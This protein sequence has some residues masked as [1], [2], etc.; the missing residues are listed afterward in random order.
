VAGSEVIETRPINQDSWAKRRHWCVNDACGLRW[1]TYEKNAPDPQF[2]I[3]KRETH[4][5]NSAQPT[6]VIAPSPPQELR[7]TGESRS[8]SGSDPISSPVF[9]DPPDLS[10]DHLQ[11]A[12]R[13]RAREAR[14]AAD[15]M[16]RTQAM[17]AAFC[18]EWKRAYSGEAY[19][20]LPKDAGQLKTFAASNADVT[21][22]LWRAACGRYLLCSTP[23]FAEARHPLSLLVGSFNQFSGE[24]K[25]PARRHGSDKTANNVA[26]LTDWLARE[27]AK[28]RGENR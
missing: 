27:E 2:A 28:E 14:S 10:K 5:G 6:T 16:Q 21:E 15:R 19:R 9:L 18:E 7:E 22:P 20:V 13:G 3:H 24:A 25:R 8:V 4:H 26:V 17:I 12:D 23:F 11:I 1:T